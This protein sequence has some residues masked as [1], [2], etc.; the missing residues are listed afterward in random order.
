MSRYFLGIVET[1][2]PYGESGEASL[3]AVMEA[4]RSFSEAVVAAG[5]SVVAGDA[6]QPSPTATFLRG[7]RSADVQRVDNPLPEVKEVFGG[8]YVI[9]APDDATAL[10]LAEQCPA[11]YGYIELRP[12][13]DFG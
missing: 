5:A 4:H 13:W 10:K 2:A 11:P 3:D 7:T 9:E 6:L 1:E 8:Y 12:V